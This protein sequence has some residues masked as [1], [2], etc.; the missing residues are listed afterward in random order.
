MLKIILRLDFLVD[1][2]SLKY[3]SLLH[4]VLLQFWLM[5]IINMKVKTQFICETK[6]VIDFFFSVRFY[7]LTK[8]T[9]VEWESCPHH[10]GSVQWNLFL[11]IYIKIKL[12]TEISS[13]WKRNTKEPAN[14]IR[15]WL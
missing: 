4:F 3:K 13:F 2:K 5:C 6:L 14:R 15:G 12:N 11:K 1:H 9:F 8:K 7:I 10:L